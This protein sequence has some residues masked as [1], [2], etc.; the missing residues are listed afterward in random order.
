MCVFGLG[1]VG[2][3]VVVFVLV[4]LSWEFIIVFKGFEMAGELVNPCAVCGE[5]KKNTV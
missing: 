2:L 3:F 1:L 4:L 5:M